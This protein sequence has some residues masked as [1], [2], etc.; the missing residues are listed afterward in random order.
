[1]E[2]LQRDRV[3][4]PCHV[5]LVGRTLESLDNKGRGSR[6]NIDFGLSVLDRELDSHPQTFPGTGSFGNVFADLLR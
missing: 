4:I 2:A 3:R 1:M 5:C 6:D